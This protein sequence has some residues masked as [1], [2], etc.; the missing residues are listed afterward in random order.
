VQ[1]I[2]LQRVGRLS[3]A[4]Q[5]LLTLAAVAGQHFDLTLLQGAAGQDGER[6]EE[7]L[8]EW[9]AR[10]LVRLRHPAPQ[11]EYDFSHD[12]IRAVVYRATR[13][14]RRRRLHR[15]VGE[16][17]EQRFGARIE[18]HAPSLAYHFE[19]AGVVEK[20]LVYLPLAAAQAAAVYANEQAL[21]Y[22]RRALALCPPSDGRRWRILLQQADVLSLVGR[23]EAASAACRE[24]LDGGDPGWQARAYG[25]LAQIYR[26]RR[27][28]AAARRCAERSERLASAG[29][30][31][32]ALSREQQRAQTLQTLGEIERAQSNL[33]RARERFEAALAI[34]EGVGDDRGR[35]NCYLG[36]GDI[37]SAQGR[38]EEA[39]GRYGE[40]VVLFR[41]VEDR[42]QAALSLRSMGMARWRLRQYDGARRAALESLEICRA[43][44]DRRGEAASLNNLGLVAI[45]QGDHPETQRALRASIA[46]YREL[47]LERRTA[48]AL[49]NLGISYMECGDFAASRESLEQA[50]EINRA[51]GTR[52]DQALDLGWLGKLAWLCMDYAA[53]VDHLERALA[54]DEEIGGGEEEDWHLIW[55]AAVACTS[56]DLAGAARYLR[57]AERAV[58]A[59][60]ANLKAYEVTRWQAALHLAS[61]DLP[62]ARTLAQQALTAAETDEADDATLGALHTLLAQA[63]GAAPSA[64]DGGARLHFERALALLPDAVPTVYPRALALHHYGEYLTESGRPDRGAACLEEARALFTRLGVD[65]PRGHPFPP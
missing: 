50:L 3:D 7:S 38:Y 48:R 55:R 6:V 64:D 24:V 17:L 15:R 40:A 19:R 9:L 11:H 16:T 35:A 13:L 25:S 31:A 49:H 36:L 39:R 37:L 8:D 65:G 45:V 1:D 22:Y 52:R 27:D 53:A 23:Y 2:V 29:D 33:A 62:R 54:L 41:G 18:A 44:G 51:A 46:L 21:D 43:I 28:Y 12:K 20:A 59:G 57:R 26:I 42:Q 10:R 61:G 60:S 5:R 34:Y 32:G 63:L 14:E 47:G 4:A 58:A 30:G 56:G